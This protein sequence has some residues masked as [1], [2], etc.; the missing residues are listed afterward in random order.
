MKGVKVAVCG[1]ERADLVLDTMKI[2]GTHFSYNEQL[3]KE[4]NIC[5]ILAN[6]QR[7]L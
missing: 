5:L 3:K 7:S 4:R 1:I 2:L 6:I